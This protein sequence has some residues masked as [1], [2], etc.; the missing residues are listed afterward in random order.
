MT[1][2][3]FDNCIRL[4]IEKDRNALKDIYTAYA[5]QIYRVILGI[6]RSPQDSEDL[7]SDFFL[8]I[9]EIA[10]TYRSGQGHKRWLTV[11]ARNLAL[12]HL[13]KNHPEEFTLDDENSS[14]YEL[15]DGTSVEENVSRKMSLDR[16]LSRLSQKERETVEMKLGMELTFTEIAELTGEPQG[17]V[18][19]RYRQA[20]SKLKQIM[21][22][23][24]L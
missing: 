2:L 22:E 19:W 12:D 17:T 23:E 15:S 1:D 21:E 7:T 18:A 3:Q 4:M 6:V 9:W 10:H 16:A 20:V 14:A 8:K 5:K 11:I 13:R 24:Q